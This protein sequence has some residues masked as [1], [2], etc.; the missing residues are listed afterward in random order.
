MA[1]RSGAGVGHIL[2]V[3][4]VLVALGLMTTGGAMAADKGNQSRDD[5]VARGAEARGAKRR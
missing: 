4:A 1:K 2:S 5:T 3:T